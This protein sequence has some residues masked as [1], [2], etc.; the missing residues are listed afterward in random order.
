MMFF[1]GDLRRNS[2]AGYAA[3]LIAASALASWNEQFPS[4]SLQALWRVISIA[5]AALPVVALAVLTLHDSFKDIKYKDISGLTG[6]F[7]FVMHGLVRMILIVLLFYS[8]RRLPSG[9]YD[10]QDWLD[11]LPFFH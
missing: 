9:V 6:S 2:M 5:S 11:F 3:V 7:M 4:T 8:F 10:T 1:V